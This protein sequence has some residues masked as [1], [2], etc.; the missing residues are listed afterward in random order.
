MGATTSPSPVISTGR[1]ATSVEHLRRPVHQMTG[2]P[3]S[4]HVFWHS[5]FFFLRSFSQ[6][7]LHFFMVFGGFLLHFFFLIL[8]FLLSTKP[9]QSS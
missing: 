1:L 6:L 4:Q 3:S 2:K 8:H 5:G 7:F 9:S